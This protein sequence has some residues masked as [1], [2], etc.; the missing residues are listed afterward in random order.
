MLL[1]NEDDKF[2][3]TFAIRPLQLFT[4]LMLRK[5]TIFERC[6]TISSAIQL[7]GSV[8]LSGCIENWPAQLLFFFFVQV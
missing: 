2:E 5:G 1:T 6:N 3:M 8:T 7:N 4:G